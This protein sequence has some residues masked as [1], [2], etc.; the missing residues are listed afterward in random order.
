VRLL[1]WLFRVVLIT[2]LINMVLRLLF[3]RPAR[4]AAAGGGRRTPPQMPAREGGTLVRDPQCGTYIPRAG[5]VQIGS[6]SDAK[7]F[8]SDTCRSAWT[9][10][11]RA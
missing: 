4:S 6:G 11:H 5:A 2:I 9:A 8:C 3:S 1:V 7:F 10:A